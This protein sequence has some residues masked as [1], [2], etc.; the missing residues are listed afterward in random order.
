MLPGRISRADILR[1]ALEQV[2]T[3]ILTDRLSGRFLLLYSRVDSQAGSHCYT[4][5]QVHRQALTRAGSHD[6]TYRQGHMTMLT[7]RLLDR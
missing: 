2:L 6:D 7:S 1:Q 4:Q 5:G 3:I